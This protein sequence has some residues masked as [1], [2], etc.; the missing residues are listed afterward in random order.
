MLQVYGLLAACTLLAFGVKRQTVFEEKRGILVARGTSLGKLL[1]FFL[2]VILVLFAGLRTVMNDTSNYI[3]SFRLN[4]PDSLAGIAVIDWSLGRNPLFTLYQILVKTLLSSNGQVFIFVTALITE[5]SVVRFLHRYSSNFSW[6]LFLFLAFTFFAFTMAAMKQTMATAI[7]IWSLPLYQQKRWWRA[8]LLLLISMLIHPYV[9]VLASAMFLIN[10]GVWNRRIYLVIVLTV[11][12]ALSFS[13]VMERILNVTDMIGDEYQEELF[14]EG[15]GVGILRILSYLIVPALAFFARRELRA[16]DNPI[17]NLFI[18]LSIL[19]ACLS[20]LSGFGGSVLFG[21]MPN[22]FDPC[23][24]IALPYVLDHLDR[25]PPRVRGLLKLA[26][27]VAYLVFYQTYYR[28]YFAV[29]P[30]PLTADIYQ[31]TTLLDILANW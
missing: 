22:Y 16:D 11:L 10:R 21:R 20:V 12:F 25:L 3:R 23:I 5:L 13:T 1:L 9:I 7:A 18:N 19:A 14:A 27:P 8:T 15:T 26:L 31:H 24:C 28:K 4:I 29:V 30:D 2:I 17:Q 6:S